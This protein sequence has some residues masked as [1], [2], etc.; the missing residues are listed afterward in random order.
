MN[1]ETEEEKGDFSYFLLLCTLP[2]CNDIRSQ[3]DIDAGASAGDF[4]DKKNTL[5]VL[6]ERVEVK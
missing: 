6:H 2:C 1:Q 4:P 5:R 3:E